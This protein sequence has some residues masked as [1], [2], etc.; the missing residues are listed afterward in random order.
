MEK[1]KK[2]H[3]KRGHE[4]VPENLKTNGSCRLCSNAQKAVAGHTSRPCKKRMTEERRNELRIKRTAWKQAHPGLPYVGYDVLSLEEKKA[5]NRRDTLKL[6]GWTP[7]TF[8][9]AK[10]SQGGRCAI[11]GDTPEVKS[12]HAEGLVSDHK[13][14]KPPKPRALLCE[15]C[16]FA[17]GKFKDSPERCEAAASYLRK[18]S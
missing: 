13:H 14:V 2:T 18:W 5:I 4:R 12:G 7:E 11:C 8:A 3:C 6:S 16:N 10:E 9:A 15:N 17:I 1:P